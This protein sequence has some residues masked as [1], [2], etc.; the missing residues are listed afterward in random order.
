[1]K[2]R[3][4]EKIIIISILLSVCL[5]VMQLVPVEWRFLAIGGLGI[6]TYLAAAFAL[7]DDLQLYEWVTILPFPVLYSLAVGSFYFLLPDSILSKIAILAI[8]ALGMYAILLTC[9]IFSVSKGRTIQLHNAAGAMALFFG[10]LVSMLLMNTV[11]SLRLDFWVNGL[12]AWAAHFPLIYTLSWAVNLESRIFGDSFLLASV[13]ALLV[14][15]LTIIL[16]FLPLAE[17]TSALFVMAFFYLIMGILQSFLTGKMFRRA[18]GE[19]A[20]LAGLVVAAFIIKDARSP[21]CSV[22][23][24][25]NRPSNIA[26]PPTW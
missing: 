14:G 3:R 18:V 8:F 19:H 25:L 21:C 1:M 15:E 5:Y 2:L 20:L 17:W 9:N 13:G 22:P 4:R 26:A 7:F 12:I 24:V 23:A 11:F 10:L 6:V 16:S